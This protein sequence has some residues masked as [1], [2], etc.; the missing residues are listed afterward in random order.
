MRRL[1]NKHASIL[2]HSVLK[3]VYLLVSNTVIFGNIL[4]NIGPVQ[5]IRKLQKCLM[6]IMFLIKYSKINGHHEE[7]N[8]SGGCRK[9]KY[10]KQTIRNK[11][12]LR[13]SCF[14]RKKEAKDKKIKK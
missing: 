14:N 9:V 11:S 7:K 1:L 2:D 4:N 6:E 10:L 3:Q 13:S 5:Y 8:S 12:I